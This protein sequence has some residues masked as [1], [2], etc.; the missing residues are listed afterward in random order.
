MATNNFFE[1][2]KKYF[3]NTPR[4]QVL[5]DWGKSLEFDNVG[6]TVEDFLNLTKKYYQTHLNYPAESEMIFKTN[7]ANPKFTSGFLFN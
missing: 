5:E 6:P 2:L 7:N 1:E 4:E 3:E